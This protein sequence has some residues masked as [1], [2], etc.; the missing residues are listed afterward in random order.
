VLGIASWYDDVR[1]H[2]AQYPKPSK[3]KSYAVVPADLGV[4]T[5]KEH[6]GGKRQHGYR[7]QRNRKQPQSFHTHHPIR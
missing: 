2:Y 1:S 3:E 4:Y 6:V 5:C 7:Y